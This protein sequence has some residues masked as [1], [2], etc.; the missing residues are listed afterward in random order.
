[1]YLGIGVAILLLGELPFPDCGGSYVS[2][3][4]SSLTDASQ[5][6]TNCIK[7]ITLDYVSRAS[8]SAVSLKRGIQ[9]WGR[10]RMASLIRSQACLQLWWISGAQT[11]YSPTSHFVSDICYWR[12]KR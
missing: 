2:R 11:I 1:M 8:N 12:S 9:D 4:G 3:P 5:A 6:H 7:L 10:Y